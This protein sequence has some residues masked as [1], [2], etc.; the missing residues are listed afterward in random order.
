MSTDKRRKEYG[1]M[2]EPLEVIIKKGISDKR[3][4][5]ELAIEIA[6]ALDGKS[7]QYASDGISMLTAPARMLIT[8]LMEPS[9]TQRALSI[10]LGISE[11]AVQKTIRQ[12]TEMKLVAKTKVQNKNMYT[13]DVDKFLNLTDIK[14]LQQAVSAAIE[15]EPF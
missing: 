12:L 11:A 5:Q 7:A 14:Y 15:S 8:L 13:V 1:G 9:M 6:K 3:S 2:T 10:Y 4:P